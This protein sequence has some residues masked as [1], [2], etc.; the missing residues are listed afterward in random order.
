[1]SRSLPMIHSFGC[2]KILPMNAFFFVI[3]AVRS[4][5]L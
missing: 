3:R 2:A 5:L 1:M 4:S